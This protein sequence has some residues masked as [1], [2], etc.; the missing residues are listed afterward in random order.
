MM[1]ST[2]AILTLVSVVIA[3]V[4]IVGSI[5]S[6]IYHRNFV[7]PVARS[8]IYKASR[9]QFFC[10][11]YGPIGIALWCFASRE[12]WQIQL[13]VIRSINDADATD[14]KKSAQ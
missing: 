3:I 5:S 7:L 14:Y 9:L 13:Q 8:A 6:I 4:A 1:W 2:E 12:V 10:K 11:H